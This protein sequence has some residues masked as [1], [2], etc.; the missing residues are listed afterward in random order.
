M[1]LH[2]FDAKIQYF[3]PSTNHPSTLHDCWTGLI[4]CHIPRSEMAKQNTLLTDAKIITG[5]ELSLL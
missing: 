4:V 2:V 3:L 5:T 1:P